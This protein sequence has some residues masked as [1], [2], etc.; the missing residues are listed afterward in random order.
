MLPAV[1]IE[2]QPSP[3]HGARREETSVD[4]LLIHYTGMTTSERALAWLC[5]PASQVSSH[6]LI[7]EDGR[8]IQLV[9][10]DRR[11][12]HAGRAFWA[13]E[14]DIN[15]R[16]IGIELVHPGHEHGYRAFADPQI[17]ALIELCGGILDRHRIPPQR[18]LAHS[19]VAPDR[20]ED[21]GELFPWSRL[22]AAD[23]GH[24]VPPE[25]LSDGPVLGTGDYGDAVEA[26][27]AR[28]HQYGYG[29]G[30]ETRFGPR[31]EA[32]VRAFQRHFR[33]ARFDGV[34]DR[35]TVE[36]LERLIATLPSSA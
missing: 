13:G 9:D 30:E 16:S 24:W 27:R 23:I 35:S 14:T 3:N 25:P 28:L 11:A 31:T 8:T 36:T 5:N 17:F 26:L 7:L 22:H 1:T 33:P 10:E 15:S 6:Y 12:W 20:K 21:P 32:V 34:A 4:I 29:I 18:V 19:D 2:H